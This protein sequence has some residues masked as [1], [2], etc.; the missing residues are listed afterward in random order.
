MTWHQYQQENMFI[1][2][3]KTL[4]TFC[5][6]QSGQHLKIGRTKLRYEIRAGKKGAGRVLGKATC[7]F[8]AIS[9]ELATRK[10][11]E[12]VGG[13][14]WMDADNVGKFIAAGYVPDPFERG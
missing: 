13:I 14:E 2:H 1:N 11:A 8:S 5:A 12:K 7:V 4:A 9:M 6:F 10:L 3:G